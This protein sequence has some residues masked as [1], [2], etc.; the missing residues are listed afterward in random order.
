MLIYYYTQMFCALILFMEIWKLRQNIY[1]IKVKQ[2]FVYEKL[3]IWR[4]C[5][6]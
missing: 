4:F 3:E 5:L 2:S 6:F 1:E